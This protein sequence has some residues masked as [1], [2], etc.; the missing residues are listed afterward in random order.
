MPEH[1]KILFEAV[2]RSFLSTAQSDSSLNPKELDAVAEV[3]TRSLAV[4]PDMEERDG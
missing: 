4:L 2:M 3:V 1:Y